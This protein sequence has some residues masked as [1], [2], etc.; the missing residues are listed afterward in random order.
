MV[1]ELIQSPKVRSIVP[2][3]GQDHFGAICAEL[4]DQVRADATRTP[5]SRYGTV[6]LPGTT[7]RAP[8]NSV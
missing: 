1:R 7:V 2:L 3:I 5:P 4:S 6:R 8:P